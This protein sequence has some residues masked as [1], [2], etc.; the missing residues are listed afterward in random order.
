[1]APVR[2]PRNA[3]FRGFFFSTPNFRPRLLARLRS[4]LKR[5][6]APDST[7]KSTGSPVDYAIISVADNL[8]GPPL[9]TFHHIN[10]PAIM[11]GFFD[12]RDHSSGSA[13]HGNRCW[14]VNG[15]VNGNR[16][17]SLLKNRP[18]PRMVVKV[19]KPCDNITVDSITLLQS[20]G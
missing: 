5:Q 16:Y 20:L 17:L 4:D 19:T 1:M 8:I 15:A 6:L 18:V 9:G 2:R 7:K 11:P 3:L 14:I 12:F 10:T 13:L